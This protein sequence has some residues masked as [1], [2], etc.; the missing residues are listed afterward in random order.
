MWRQLTKDNGQVEGLTVEWAVMVQRIIKVETLEPRVLKGEE[1]IAA[2]RADHEKRFGN[3]EDHL[4]GVRGE[5]GKLAT[6]IEGQIGI[7]R[8]ELGKQAVDDSRKLNEMIRQLAPLLGQSNDLHS[9]M[10]A[11]ANSQ[12]DIQKRLGT[13]EEY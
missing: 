6:N 1:L 11:L 2:N 12:K 9:T 10:T 13:L 8:N 4:A 5:L 3:A 7:A